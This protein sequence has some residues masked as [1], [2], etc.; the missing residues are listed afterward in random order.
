MPYFAFYP[1]AGMEEDSV[2]IWPRMEPFLLGALQV[3]IPQQV[4]F[5]FYSY[6]LTLIPPHLLPMSGGTLLQTGPSLPAQ[7]GNLCADTGWKFP[8][9]GL[10]HVETHRLWKATASR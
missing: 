7:N 1:T 4:K 6:Q 10:A 5:I 3:I 2:S 8:H 9:A